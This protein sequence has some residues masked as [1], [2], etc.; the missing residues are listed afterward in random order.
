MD[1]TNTRIDIIDTRRMFEPSRWNSP[2]PFSVLL[3]TC[4]VSNESLYIKKKVCLSVCLSVCL[5][6]MHLDTVRASAAK[7]S[8]NPLLNQEKV[9][10]YFFPKNYKSF[11]RKQTPLFPTN[12]IAAFLG[13]GDLPYR[14]S[15]SRRG[16]VTI[17][18]RGRWV[19]IWGPFAWNPISWLRT[20][21]NSS[22][23]KSLNLNSIVA[24]T[25]LQGF[26]ETA[27]SNSMSIRLETLLVD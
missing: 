27:S 1:E 26:S 24:E 9:E 15:R 22:T 6:F 16:Q 14:T 17:G 25:V 20:N 18:F 5:F 21:R 7:L 19:R 23:V 11:P 4:F 2:S 12:G 3:F 8:R 13:I 10:S